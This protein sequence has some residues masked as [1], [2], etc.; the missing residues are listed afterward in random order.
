MPPYRLALYT[1]ATLYFRRLYTDKSKDAMESR[2]LKS[3]VLLIVSFPPLLH[4]KSGECHRAGPLGY[5]NYVYS[6][7]QVTEACKDF[8]RDIMA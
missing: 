4:G 7:A 8:L 3:S 1:A 2:M 6:I 5:I